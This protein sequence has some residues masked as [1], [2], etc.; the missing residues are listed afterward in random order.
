MKHSRVFATQQS[1]VHQDISSNS[2]NL[3]K[4]IKHLMVLSSE[5]QKKYLEEYICE[6]TYSETAIGGFFV[7]YRF[8]YRS[9]PISRFRLGWKKLITSWQPLH[10]TVRY[11]NQNSIERRIYSIY[12]MHK[13]EYHN[14]VNVQRNLRRN[15]R[16]F[17]LWVVASLCCCSCII[18]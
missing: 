14:F 6:Y 17:V 8:I 13:N 18:L 5:R 10:L 1:Q 2:V 7:R 11:A 4:P 12:D 3:S 15:R 16:V 9:K